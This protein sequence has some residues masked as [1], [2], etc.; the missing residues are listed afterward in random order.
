M[1]VVIGINPVDRQKRRGRKKQTKKKASDGKLI[2][3]VRPKR[4]KTVARKTVARATPATKTKGNE[5]MAKKRGRKKAKSGGGGKVKYR[6]RTK[7]IRQYVKKRAAKKTAK[8]KTT[9]SDALN[10]GRMFRAAGAVSIGM[11]V[12][13]VAVNKLTE[14][15]SEKQAWTWPNIFMAAG[16]SIVAAF[17]LGAFGMKK[18]CVALVAVGG[19]GLA[20]YKTFTCKIAPKWGWTEDWFGE[21]AMLPSAA[22]DLEVPEFEPS[23]SGF[24]GGGG[25]LVARNPYMGQAGGGGQLVPRNPAMGEDN[26]YQRIARTSRAMYATGGMM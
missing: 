14:G 11:I 17:V 19:V 1:P 3:Y 10:L 5:A 9:V 23:Y 24:G 7:V 22:A 20:L 2:C 26:E 18:P 6:T 25:Q 15:G 8:R 13:K 12:A 4:K 21:D 16:S